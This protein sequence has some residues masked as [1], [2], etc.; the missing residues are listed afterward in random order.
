MP[1]VESKSKKDE[2]EHEA[3]PIDPRYNWFEEV[4]CRTFKLKNDKFKVNF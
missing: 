2:D 3:K 1:E 4:V